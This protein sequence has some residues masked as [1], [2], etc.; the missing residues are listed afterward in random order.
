M[1]MIELAMKTNTAD[2]TIGSQRTVSET[3][4]ASSF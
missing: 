2:R 1:W 3:I 4:P